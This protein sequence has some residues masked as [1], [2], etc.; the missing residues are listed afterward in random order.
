MYSL[1]NNTNTGAI[2]VSAGALQ[3]LLVASTQFVSLAI[4]LK[5]LRMIGD[6][7]LDT[8]T[9]PSVEDMLVPPSH[10]LSSRSSTQLGQPLVRLVTPAWPFTQLGQPSVHQVDKHICYSGTNFRSH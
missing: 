8:I 6:H 3:L 9:A 4:A 10:N 2:S 5:A 7:I 1:F